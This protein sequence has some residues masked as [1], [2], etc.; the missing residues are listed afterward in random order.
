MYFTL[1]FSIAMSLSSLSFFFCN[2][3]SAVDPM[4]YSFIFDIVVF[5]FRNFTLVFFKKVCF[6]ISFLNFY[7]TII[8]TILTFFSADSDICGSS[9]LICL[10][11]LLIMRQIFQLLCMPGNSWLGARHYEFCLIE[12]PIVL[13]SYKYSR[14]LFWNIVKL[15]ENNLILLPLPLKIHQLGLQ[16]C[17]V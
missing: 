11:F 10:T 8:K 3:L 13:C 9:G 14:A 4:Q 16:Q 5:I 2:V 15:Y 6:F 7:N 17:L 12:C 1:D